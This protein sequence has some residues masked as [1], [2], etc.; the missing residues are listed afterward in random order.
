MKIN[1][2]LKNLMIIYANSYGPKVLNS[3]GSDALAN[4]QW[5]NFLVARKSDRNFLF[6]K[7]HFK[8][9]GSSL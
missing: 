3:A 5:P 8:G 4:M 9:V 6:L 1:I 7:S 2:N